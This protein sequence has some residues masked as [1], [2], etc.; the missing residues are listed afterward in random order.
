MKKSIEFQTL[1]KFIFPYRRYLTL[2]TI[3]LANAF[4]DSIGNSGA[5]SSGGDRWSLPGGKRASSFK[6]W[7]KDYVFHNQGDITGDT[8]RSL[9]NT[10][11][12]SYRMP[13]SIRKQS[14]RNKRKFEIDFGSILKNFAIDASIF[15]VSSPFRRYRL[16]RP[17]DMND[18]ECLDF[19]SDD[20]ED[21]Y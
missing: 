13:A 12:M 2:Q 1:F 8:A 11:M 18:Q 15:D 20:E 10:F 6:G 17:Y 4:Y 19:D 21:D 5:P 16:E 9:M 14:K 3:Y 7:E